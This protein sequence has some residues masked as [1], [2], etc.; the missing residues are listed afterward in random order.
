[1]ILNGFY[2]KS[3]FEEKKLNGA[4]DPLPPSW[5]MPLNISLFFGGNPFLK[6]IAHTEAETYSIAYYIILINKKYTSSHKR[7]FLD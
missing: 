4:R 2:E 6:I 3:F 7:I 5:Q 1:M